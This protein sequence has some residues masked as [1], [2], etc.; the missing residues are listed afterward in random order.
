MRSSC[1]VC[2][3]EL[4]PILRRVAVPVHQKNLRHWGERIQ[5]LATR[6]IAVWGAGAKGMTFAHLLDPNA[7]LIACLVDINPT[8][9]RH[10]VPGTGHPIVAPTD[11]RTRQT[12]S[13]ILMNPNYLVE[14]GQLTMPLALKVELHVAS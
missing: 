10:F 3:S 13:A 5:H 12:N 2:Q 4:S 1:P 14:I 8:K 7:S 9:Q 11:L 6:G